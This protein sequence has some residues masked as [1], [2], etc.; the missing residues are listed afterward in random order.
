MANQQTLRLRLRLLLLL[1]LF[2]TGNHGRTDR[3]C[4]QAD[5]IETKHNTDGA[6]DSFG[7]SGKVV[8]GMGG[9]MH[10]VVGTRKVIVAMKHTQKGAPKILK[11]CTLPL[12]ALNCAD[13][14]EKINEAFTS[15]S[16]LPRRRP[17]S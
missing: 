3:Q 13:L 6:T 8:P 7:Q 5:P 11:K 12:T 17:N 4:R 14:I 2:L 10:L 16:S 15:Q 9:A 1:L